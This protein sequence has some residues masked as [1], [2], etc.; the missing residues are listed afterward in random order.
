M[1]IKIIGNCSYLSEIDTVDDGWEKG[2]KTSD[3]YIIHER[4]VIFLS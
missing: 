3:L 2:E 4:K 1:V